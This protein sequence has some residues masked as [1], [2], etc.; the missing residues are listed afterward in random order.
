M[1]RRLSLL[2]LAAQKLS[3]GPIHTLDLAHQVLELRGNPPVASKAVFTLLGRDPR[4]GVDE[5][6]YWC[7]KPGEASLGVP[8]TRLRYSVVDVETTGGLGARG[9]RVTEVAIVHIDDG[10]IGRSFQTLVNP[11][12]PIPPRIQGFTGITD[13]MVSV[14]PYFE[15]IAEAV[16]EHLRDRVFVAH[17]ERFD[18]G[19]IRR[20]LLTAGCEIPDLERLCTVRLGRLLIP[21][22]RSYGLD[23]LTAHF[24]IRVEQRH[25]AFGDALATARLL[26][27]L[28]KQAEA[29]GI[30]DLA[31]LQSAQ[32]RRGRRR[33]AKSRIRNGDYS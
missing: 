21:R 16:F 7:L 11:G 15:G 1:G 28:L 13:G 31:S 25:R 26:L 29:R 30:S 17:N 18:W 24:R 27:H 3:S 5:N 20:E 8:L 9:D 4:F 33:R 10:A 19:M 32:G 22:L 23:S 6:G 14:A 2:E 12:R